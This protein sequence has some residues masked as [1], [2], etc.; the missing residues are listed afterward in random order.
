MAG[1]DNEVLFATNVDFRNVSPV[2][3]QMTTDGQLLIGATASPNIRA[4]FLASA[5]SSVTISNGAGTINLAVTG[6]TTT[7]K[8][9]TGDT[10]GALPPTGGNWNILG[11]AAQGVST[12]GAGSTLTLTVASSTE[13]QKGVIELATNAETIAGSD[14]ERAVTPDDLKAKLGAQTNHGLPIGASQTAALTWTAAPTNGQILIGST[15]SDPVL[16]VPTNGNNITWSTGAGSLTANVTGTTNHAIQLGNASGS[17][18]SLGVATNGQ[19]PIGSTGADPVLATLTQGTGISITNGAGSITIAATGAG[20][21]WTDQGTNTTVASNNG[22]FATA[23][24]NLT[25]PSSPSQGDVVKIIADT[26]SSVTVTGNTGQTIRL[27]NTISATAGTAVNTQ[28]GDAIELVYRSTGAVWL[29]IS[30]VGSWTI[31]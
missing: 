19:L 12:S 11:T 25:L 1:F 14:T 3:A 23:A 9:I 6:G 8:T 16:A 18:T 22:Y 15:G 30:S 28:R 7:G 17:L 13:T 21:P 29:S 20:F 4:G 26:T 5:D 31:T 27:G 2:Q 10:G 24:V